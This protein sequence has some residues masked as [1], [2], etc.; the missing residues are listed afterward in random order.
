MVLCRFIRLTQALPL[1]GAGVAYG[2]DLRWIQR[3][4]FWRLEHW[5]AEHWIMAQRQS[6]WPS[7]RSWEMHAQ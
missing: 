7:R 1:V 4:R 6:R 3:S 2:V 5:S